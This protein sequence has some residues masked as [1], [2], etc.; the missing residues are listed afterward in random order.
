MIL[1]RIEPLDTHAHLFRVRLSLS[2]PAAQQRLS[3]PVWIPGSY[4]VRE[5]ARHLQRLTATQGG[6]EVPLRQLDK[7]SWVAECAGAE[8]LELAWEVYAFDTSVRAAFLDAGRGFFNGTGVFLRAEGREHEPHELEIGGLPPGWQVATALPATDVDA[9]GA[10]RYR[11]AD[12]DE[13]VDHPVELGRFW[14]GA[15]T[16]CGVPHEFVVAGAP[17]NFDGERL[18][19]DTQKICE[20]QIR[21]W[22]GERAPHFGRYVFL[23]NAVDDGYGGLEHRASTALICA[24]RELPRQGEASLG[25]GYL[26]LLGL[27]SHEYFHTWNVKRLRPAEFARYDYA[28]ENYTGLLWFFEGFTSYYDDLFLVRAGLI[29]E[30]RY[31]KQLAKGVNNT[32]AMPGRLVQSVAQASFDAWIR[33]YRQDE[34]TANSTVSYYA[35]GSLVALAFDLTLRREGRGTLDAVMHVLWKRSQGG[36]VSEADIAAAF[37]HVGGRSYAAEFAAWVHG[38]AELPIRELLAALAVEWQAEP[39]TVAQRLGVRA[40]EALGV[41]LKSVLRGSAAEQAGLAAGDE[42]LAVNDW[43]LRKLDE[44]PFYVPA[45]MPLQWL[46]SRDQRVLRLDGAP[47]A[48]AEGAVALKPAAQAAGDA[49]ALRAAWLRP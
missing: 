43:R 35:K 6:R 28:Q 21:F 36:P 16:A 15:F 26:T 24:R 1:Y 20:A 10:G 44:I 9:D 48:D 12:Y 46:V 42:L 47:L 31:L 5:F 29:D 13:L 23:L 7:A 25:E 27:I 18:L 14:R 17:P 30:A 4:L 11:A 45:G 41:K 34:N 49:L 3:L 38:T 33:Y 39:A 8:P 22:H 37:E 32:L 2:Q 19:R 40:T